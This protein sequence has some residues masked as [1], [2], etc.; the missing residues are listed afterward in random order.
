[1]KNIIAVLMLAAALALSLQAQD[2]STPKSASTKQPTKPEDLSVYYKSWEPSE[3]KKCNTYSGQRWLLICDADD[4]NWPESLY[5]QVGRNAGSGLSESESYENA[6][7]HTRANSKHFLV[8]FSEQPW[9]APHEGRK[10]ALWKC[11]KTTKI[12]CKLMGRE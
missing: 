1:M 4:L 7:T 5:R 12:S 8:G 11:T 6:F 10:L 3:I 9:P 2:K